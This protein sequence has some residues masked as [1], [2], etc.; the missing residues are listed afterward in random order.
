M[1]ERVENFFRL[2]AEEVR[3]WL[4]YL[5]ARSLDE[6]VGRTDLLEQLDVAPR[7]GV[8]VD[9]SRLLA[10]ARYEGAHCALYYSLPPLYR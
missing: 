4:S 3:Q 6:I 5:G 2:L 7:E 8:K 1:P 10:P 9:L